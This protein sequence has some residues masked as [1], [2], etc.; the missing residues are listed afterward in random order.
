MKKKG[1]VFTTSFSPLM[2]IIV[3]FMGS[4]ILAEQIFLGRYNHTLHEF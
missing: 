3:A 2:M 1:P 4:F